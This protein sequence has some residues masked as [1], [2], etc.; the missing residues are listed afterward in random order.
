[1]QKSRLLAV[2]L[3]AALACSDPWAAALAAAGQQAEAQPPSIQAAPTLTF[4]AGTSAV[5]IDVVVRDK[6]GNLV[7]DL[8]AADFELE[9]DG[10]KQTIESFLV[11]A[12]GVEGLPAP[13]APAQAATPPAAAPAPAAAAPA[14]AA[15]PTTEQPDSPAVMA[16]VFDNMSAEGRD[17]ARKAAMTY[18]T[19]RQDG[20]FV[21]IFSIDLALHVVQSFTSDPDKIREGI[22][23]GSA[24]AGANFTS[25]TDMATNLQTLEQRLVD[26]QNAAMNASSGGGAGSPG[27]NPSGVMAMAG[28]AAVERDIARLQVGMMRSF[29]A[30]ERDQ[31]GMATSNGL[32]SVVQGLKRVPGRKTVVFFSEGMAIPD[33]VLA[34][35]QDLVAE[36]NRA[37][38]AI[39]T[40]DSGGLRTISP[41]EQ[42]RNELRAAEERRYRNLGKEDSEMG[43]MMRDAERN[44]DLLRYNPQ[45]G[46]GRLAE[47]TGGFM[48]RDTNDARSGFRQIA[49]DMRFHYVLGYTPTNSNYDGRFRNVSVKVVKRGGVNVHSRRGYFAVRAATSGPVRAYE[50]PAIAVLEKPGAQKETFPIRVM[51]L[52]FPTQPGLST[53]PVM[54]RV[55]GSALKYAPATAEKD[56]MSADLAV[57]ARVRNEYQQEVG[58]MSQHYALSSPI[59]KLEAARAGDILF[60]RQ[61]E[62]PPG[63][64]TVDLVAYDKL[65]EKASVKSLPLEVPAPDAKGVSLG[66]LMVIDHVEAVPAAER[67]AT[68]PLYMGEMLV[69]PSMGA[70][71]RK[72][73][74]VM[75]YYFTAHAPGAP[76]KAVLEVVK[77]GQVASKMM[78]SLP[79]PDTRGLVQHANALPLDPFA[80]GSYELRVSLLDGTKPVA[81]RSTAFTLAE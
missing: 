58:R 40:M 81:T 72:A 30:L 26:G 3:T 74:K 17:T 39:Y 71:V 79:A 45:A 15:V 31:Q 68:N 1:M 55:P 2:V 4:A 22:D 64:Y 24:R 7:K 61:T 73:G 29:E 49:Q 13:G 18:M 59:A 48:V 16:M 32:L 42:T 77:G 28:G 6:K 41:T 21:G 69:Y 63:R 65:G 27:T 37:N 5:A 46:L 50:A 75:G 33:R 67:D 56:T 76:R 9:E 43:I 25:T 10:A 20:D 70:P 53:V 54:A 66:S 52:T 78:L 34:Q 62:L 47:Q 57:V 12:R 14:P 11:V 35:F 19:A 60:Y 36:A 8:S 38:V 23:R 80:P 44:E 51:A